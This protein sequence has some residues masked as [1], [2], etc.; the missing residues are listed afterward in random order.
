MLLELGGTQCFDSL[1]WFSAAAVNAKR[2]GWSTRAKPRARHRSHG[3][4]MR[5]GLRIVRLAEVTSW[6]YLDLD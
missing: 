1:P 2:H 6:L 5:P 3:G 4:A